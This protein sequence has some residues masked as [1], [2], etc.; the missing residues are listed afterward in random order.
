MEEEVRFNTV[1]DVLPGLRLIS[2]LLINLEQA[3]LG[4]EEERGAV[5]CNTVMR[6]L[7]PG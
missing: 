7:F 4:R 6:L 3:A 2:E 5:R 1:V